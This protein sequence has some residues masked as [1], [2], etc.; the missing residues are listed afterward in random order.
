M[1]TKSARPSI[2]Q[3]VQ[4]QCFLSAAAVLE[5]VDVM[6]D[7]TAMQSA[8]PGYIED[9]QD[10][11]QMKLKML[12]EQALGLIEEGKALGLQSGV[13][14]DML[15]EAGICFPNW[16]LVPSALQKLAEHNSRQSS[17]QKFMD[18]VEKAGE[19]VKMLGTEDN[20]QQQ[21]QDLPKQLHACRG[22]SAT[23]E[24]K[25]SLLSVYDSMLGF[26]QTN[27]AGLEQSL[28]EPMLDAMR[29]VVSDFP[30]AEDG[31]R[32]AAVDGWRQVLKLRSA[33]STW[34]KD[35]PNMDDIMMR[36]GSQSDLE[37]FLSQLRKVEGMS[38][39]KAE[40]IDNT[41]G[42]CQK[43]RSG[44]KSCLV[45]KA[46]EK[47]QETVLKVKRLAGGTGVENQFWDE[48]LTA[49]CPW[50]T[51]VQKGKETLAVMD[52][53]LEAPLQQL[54]EA[55]NRNSGVQLVGSQVV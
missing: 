8:L 46:T 34:E 51:L 52:P 11:V 18:L 44:A 4:C 13:V 31:E 29:S 14:E 47:L 43:L 36:S 12:W 17:K 22:A 16:E 25:K 19:F 2:S 27:L 3:T 50:E 37:A 45:K 49:D 28:A 10:K 5:I 23:D 9:I 39:P 54:E 7:L 48:D 35:E 26:V 55:R 24:Q 15:A 30:G 1:E 42:R 21:V 41:V 38:L 33:A 53:T 6:K 40:V 20:W 32:Q